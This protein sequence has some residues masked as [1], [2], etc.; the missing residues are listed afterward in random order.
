[1]GGTGLERPRRTCLG[2][3]ESVPDELL[4][5]VLTRGSF[6]PFP[7]PIRK[8]KTRCF[9][10]VLMER[11]MGLEPTTFCMASRCSTN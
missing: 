10:R 9:Q 1:M 2:H 8:Q 4:T 11:M 6:H 5:Q 7:L 3:L